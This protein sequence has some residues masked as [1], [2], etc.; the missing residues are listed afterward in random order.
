MYLALHFPC[1]TL[2]HDRM[3]SYFLTNFGIHFVT[4]VLKKGAI[5]RKLIINIIR[6]IIRNSRLVVSVMTKSR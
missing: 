2:K 6:N 1:K 3:D 4:L 5:E